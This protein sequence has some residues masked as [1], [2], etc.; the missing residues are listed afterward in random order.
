MMQDRPNA[1]SLIIV[2][3]RGKQLQYRY[4]EEEVSGEESSA[5]PD[6]YCEVTMQPDEEAERF[7]PSTEK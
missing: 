6:D 2:N 3:G 1:C 5:M 4:D 7:T